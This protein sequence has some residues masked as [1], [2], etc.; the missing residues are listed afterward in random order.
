MKK[1]TL[2][3]AFLMAVLS[4]AQTLSGFVANPSFEDGSVGTIAQFQT[5]NDWKLGG[6]NAGAT[7]VS[8]SI[9]SI[10]VHP[11]DGSNAIEV[12]SVSEINGTVNNDWNITLI[13]TTYPFNGNNTDPI[14]VTVS[15]WAKTTDTDPVSRN[16]NGD[17]RLL[18]KDTGSSTLGNKQAR[19]LLETDTWVNITKTFTYDAA[20]DYS[21]SLYFDVGKVDGTTQIDGISASVTGGATLDASP[22]P[23]VVTN[24]GFVTNPSFDDGSGGTIPQWQ[25]LDNWKL[26][27]NLATGNNYGIIQTNDVYDG[28]NALEVANEV[29]ANEWQNKVTSADYAFDGNNTDPIEVTVSFWAKTTDTDPASGNPN[30]DLKVVVHDRTGSIDRTLRANLLT[31]TWTNHTLTFTTFPA[32]ASYTLA[33]SFQFGKLEGVT[34]IDGITSSVTGGAS[35]GLDDIPKD[36]STVFIYPNPVM[37]VLNYTAE[38]VKNIEVY[39]LLG[40]KLKAE[41]A[42]GSINTSTFPKGSYILR[43]IS[44]NGAVSTKKFIK[45]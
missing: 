32:A 26:E 5:L 42:V 24:Y 19:V 7:G 10:D 11:G 23:A 1:I 21:L 35:L 28:S 40:Q 34:H 14:E 41:K 15:F 31:N 29:A 39:N 3:A 8:A 12:T 22:E 44:E 43:L 20:A 25:T 2:I 38:G 45:E 37:N 27:G 6:G 36:D 4:Y 18:I 33:L 13:N 17:M 16:P 30:G 9:Q